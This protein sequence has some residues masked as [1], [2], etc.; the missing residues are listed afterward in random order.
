[1]VAAVVEGDV[2][3]R[4]IDAISNGADGL[5]DAT[6]NVLAGG[7]DSISKVADVV[8]EGTEKATGLNVVDEAI[9]LHGVDKCGGIAGND[10]SRA[11]NTSKKSARVARFVG[12]NNV[13]EGGRESRGCSEG[14]E[15]E[16]GKVRRVHCVIESKYMGRC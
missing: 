9:A 11:V 7:H 14:G 8:N 3:K 4:I 5:P 2:V 13:R 12:A 10:V 16:D 6:Y 1:M 15:E